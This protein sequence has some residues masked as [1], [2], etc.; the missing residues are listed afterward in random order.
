MSYSY[1][2]RVNRFVFTFYC[3]NDDMDHMLSSIGVTRDSLTPAKLSEHWTR[4][5]DAMIHHMLNIYEFESDE[6]IKLIVLDKVYRSEVCFDVRPK[7]HF[8]FFCDCFISNFLAH[9]LYEPIP[10]ACDAAIIY[11]SDLY[12]YEKM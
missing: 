10:L 8:A 11:S 12:C 1:E 6:I 5:K 7:R 9:Y 3:D 2:W 4:W